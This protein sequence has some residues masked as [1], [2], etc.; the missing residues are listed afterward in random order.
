MGRMC[1]PFGRTYLRKLIDIKS[2]LPSVKSIFER[3]IKIREH[4]SNLDIA[5]TDVLLLLQP[6]IQCWHPDEQTESAGY[7]ICCPARAESADLPSA[8]LFRS[9]NSSNFGIWG[10]TWCKFRY[11]SKFSF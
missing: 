2:E 11:R 5:Q 1:F 3:Y 7:N 8:I 9:N 4:L 10:L 6:Q